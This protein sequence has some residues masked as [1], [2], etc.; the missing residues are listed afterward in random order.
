[1][2]KNE[3]LDG[4]NSRRIA[5][6]S[7]KACPELGRRGQQP[8]YAKATAGSPAFIAKLKHGV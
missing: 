2:N 5:R 1:M 3:A 8:S 7:A 4:L 6:N